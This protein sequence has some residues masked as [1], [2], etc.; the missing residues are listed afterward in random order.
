MHIIWHLSE[1]PALV[2][3]V[4]ILN[5]EGG[6]QE[7]VSRSEEE[8]EGKK[9]GILLSCT[10]VHCVFSLLL[11]PALLPVGPVGSFL[12]DSLVC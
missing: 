4:R 5:W 1:S 6:Q 9:E 11:C 2:K 10:E 8:E 12:C 7:E 3:H